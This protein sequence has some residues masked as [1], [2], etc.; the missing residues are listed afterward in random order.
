MPPTKAPAPLFAFGP[1]LRR[2]AQAAVAGVARE[3]H[4]QG[5]W[6]AKL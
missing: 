2:R 5:A 3:P 1:G 6:P 4:G